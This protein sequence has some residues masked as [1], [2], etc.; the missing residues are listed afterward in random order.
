MIGWR[1]TAGPLGSIFSSARALGFLFFSF[2]SD[3]D[4]PTWSTADG[5]AS[6]GVCSQYVHIYPLCTWLGLLLVLHWTLA[7]PT[8]ID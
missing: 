2:S 1:P 4:R 8:A 5:L 3:P 6:A 7:V